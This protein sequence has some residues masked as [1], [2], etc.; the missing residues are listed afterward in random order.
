MKA[1]DCRN[2]T[3]AGHSGSGKTTLAELML[4][5]AKAIDRRGSIEQKNTASDYTP[6]EQEKQ[7]SL[8]SAT[9]HL[10]WKGKNLFFND[11]PG[12]AEFVGEVVSCMRAAD[13][14]MVLVDA[15]DGPQIGTARSW[16]MA[17][18]RKIPA[19]GVISRLDRERADFAGTLEKLRDT[20]GRGKA[21]PITWP[22]GAEADLKK[23]V[24]VLFDKDI[25][26]DIAAEVEEVR[27]LWMDA[28]AETDEELMM[29]Y[30]DGETLG[31][32]EIAKGLQAA[33]GSGSVI[34]ILAVSAAKD[35]GVDEL[36]D[37]IAAYF[38]SPLNRKVVFADGSE[39]DV[40]DS[41]SAVGLVFKSINDPFTGQLSLVRVRSGVFRADSEVQNL[42]RNGKERF[43][44][45]L[46]LNGKQ[47]TPVSEVGPGGIFAIAK[48]KDTH[49][50]DT[51]A[52]GGSK[53]LPP[54]AYPAPVMSF[55]LTAAKSGEDDKM[56]TALNKLAECDPTIRTSRHPETHEMLL[57]GM[58]DQHLALVM[59]RLREL[60]KVE[61][62]L[63]T[64]KVPYRETIAGTGESAYR[65]KKQSGGAGQFAEV[66]LR[67][68][69][70][71]EGYE[72][73]NAIVGGAIPKNFIPAVEKGVLEMLA[74]GPLV[75]CPVERVRVTVFDGKY[76]PVDSNEMAFKIASR[77]AFK[78]A[79]NKAH[80][81]LLEPIMTLHVHVPDS[82]MGNIT[83]D[84]NHKRGRIIGMEVEEGLNVVNAEVPMAELPKYATELRSMTQGR[85]F[86]ELEF[87]R[88]EEVP[89]HIAGEIIAKH[90]AEVKEE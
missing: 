80:P 30:L 19:I 9:L 26:A 43:G 10:D 53:E 45:L 61:A 49:F 83:G 60:Y 44:Q 72:F 75:G 18:D 69:P 42:T 36:L 79:M 55:A 16:K 68:E 65:H 51:L 38:P 39:Q 66:H 40:S 90:Q 63:S 82:D 24:N 22:V 21:L 89:A 58:G 14:A 54:I 59:K 34:P 57:S 87:A 76:H 71:E 85:G 35:V 12:Y 8:N 33:V 1:A 2:F 25:P 81:V 23:V 64:P 48:L 77:Q 88:Y 15:V 28:I 56:L 4:F 32:E 67:I 37:F 84:L 29:R 50:G 5:K 17:R 46:L 74:Q 6:E 70:K 62:I 11:T 7:C 47:Q 13:S 78:E 31:D 3:I 27:G 20:L 41:G 73:V 86:F 52:V